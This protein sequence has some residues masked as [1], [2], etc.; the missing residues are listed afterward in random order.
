[1]P[2]T[3]PRLLADPGPAAE[4]FARET[5]RRLGQVRAQ[6]GR[7][8]L[9]LGHHYMSD[10]VIGWAD[11]VGD[12]L[13]LSRLAATQNEA[14][15]IVFCGVHFMAETADILAGQG[16]RVILPARGAGCP[17]ADMAAPEQVEQCWQ[18]LARLDGG[19]IIPITYVNSSARL[20]AFCGRHGGAVCTSS[21]ARAVLAWAL[22]QGRRALFFPDQHLGRNTA[23]ALGLTPREIATWR[24]QAAVLEGEAAQARVIV[25]DGFCPV[26]V[27]FGPADVARARARQAGVK[28]VVHPECP[29]QVVALADDSGSTEKIIGLVEAAPAGSAWAIGTEI[30][31]VRRLAARFADKTIFSLNESVAGCPDM[32]KISPTNLL[33][34]LEAI[35]DGKPR[36]VVGVDEATA[37]QAAVALERMFAVS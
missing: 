18:E 32:A 9:I 6:L 12:S 20:K 37:R 25:W 1:M 3:R 10:A 30:N 19:P 2:Q 36:G 26:H 29:S 4:P 35:L 21:N 28:V 34:S 27:E 16:R 13:A 15:F 24:R 14:E 33:A 11:A 31:L 5:I 22:G 17:M 23:L 7:R 8:A